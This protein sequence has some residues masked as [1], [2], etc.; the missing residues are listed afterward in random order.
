[1][2]Y[3][4][5]NN[6]SSSQTRRRD[7]EERKKPKQWA[8]CD[9]KKLAKLARLAKKRQKETKTKTKQAKSKA[10]TKNSFKGSVVAG[11]GCCCC[12]WS[13]FCCRCWTTMTL[14]TLA[15]NLL[16]LPATA[17]QQADTRD[18]L[19]LKTRENRDPIPETGP[20]LATYRNR[21]SDVAH[22]PP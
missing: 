10:V 14:A 6:S 12:C 7:D 16:H 13:C 3:E 17:A 18:S 11:C 22:P 1:M 5:K 9:K 19:K 15:G 2:K 8:T 4:H 20:A 21:P